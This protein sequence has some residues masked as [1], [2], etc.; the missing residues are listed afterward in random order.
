MRYTLLTYA[1]N[2]IRLRAAE[3]IAEMVAKIGVVLEVTPQ[4]MATVD[5]QVWPEFDVAAG[6]NFD[7]SMWGW[8]AP[9]MLTTQMFGGLVHS[10]PLR[11]QLN[12]G[13]Y[14]SAKAD[15]L[16]AEMDRA[17]EAGARAEAIV[18]LQELMR[19]QRPFVPLYYEN[20]I[21]AYRPDAYDGWVF[22]TGQGIMWRGSFVRYGG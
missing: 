9:V 17:V 10:D 20:R 4:E 19:D 1:N 13:G 5:E 11:G 18:A 3:L 6:R 12:I 14:R 8:S 22:Q 21:F 15:A 7:L 2:P 16:I